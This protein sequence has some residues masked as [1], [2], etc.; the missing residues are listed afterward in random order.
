MANHSP[1]GTEKM[2]ALGRLGGQKSGEIRRRNAFLL[3]MLDL[4]SVRGMLGGHLTLEQVAEA[5]RPPDQSSG[6]HDTDWRCPRC[7]HFSSFKRRACAKCASLAPA[8][9]RLTRAALRERQ[10]EHRTQAILAKHGI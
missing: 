5:M 3:R 9:G 8:N 6:D 10:A 2:R 7:G 4:Y 1:K